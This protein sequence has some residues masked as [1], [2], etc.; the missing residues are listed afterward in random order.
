MSA[1]KEK[2]AET[3]AENQQESQTHDKRPLPPEITQ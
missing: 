2:P 3:F 1:K